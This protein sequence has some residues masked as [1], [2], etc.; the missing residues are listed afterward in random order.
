METCTLP[1]RN[2]YCFS[3]A[4]NG[5]FTQIW[6]FSDYLLTLIN[7]RY[8]HSLKIF[9]FLQLS[10]SFSAF[11]SPSFNDVFLCHNYDCISHHFDFISHNLSYSI[12]HKCNL[13]SDNCNL[14]FHIFSNFWLY[15]SQFL[16][17]YTIFL[18]ISCVS[19]NVTL[20]LILN[21]I[22]Q[23]HFLLWEMGINMWLRN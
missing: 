7:Y 11:F 17:L 4:L 18:Y 10:N 8:H 20:F 12:Y 1:I 2:I 23:L 15:I 22:S 21:C 3:V 16:T 19:H 13:I 5:Y 6:T 9:T 14:I